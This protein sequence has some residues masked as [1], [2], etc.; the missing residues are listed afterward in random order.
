VSHGRAAAGRPATYI[1]ETGTDLSAGPND[2]SFPEYAVTPTQRVAT[3]NADCK[4]YSI[5]RTEFAGSI[6][7]S[8]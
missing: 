3:G 2:S 4:T 8:F 5:L 6:A 1:A 7:C